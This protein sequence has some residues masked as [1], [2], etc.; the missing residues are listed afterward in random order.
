MSEREWTPEEREAK[1]QRALEMNLGRHLKP[2][3]PGDWWT[4]EELALLGTVADEQVAEK[5][6]RSVQAVRLKRE[7][8][9]IPNPTNSSWTPEEDQLVLTLS[10]KEAALRT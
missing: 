4:D 6:K 10:I 5:V 8:M 1:R 7:R 2:G 3:Y 9:G